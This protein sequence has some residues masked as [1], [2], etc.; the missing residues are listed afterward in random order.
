MEG[1]GIVG[2]LMNHLMSRLIELK[3]EIQ[4]IMSRYQSKLNQIGIGSFIKFVP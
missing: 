1:I 4:V 2:H 3:L